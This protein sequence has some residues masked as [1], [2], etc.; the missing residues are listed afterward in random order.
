MGARRQSRSRRKSSRQATVQQGPLE[1][2]A[3]VLKGPGGSLETVERAV[4]KQQI[5][6]DA[7]GA[8]GSCSEGFE[9]ARRQSRN[10]RKSSRQATD[11]NHAAGPLEA[12]ARVLKGP[13][14][15]LETVE[16]AVGKQ[17]I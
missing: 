15:S 12:A 7:A 2:A 8:T 6:N 17:Q 1:A 4:G 11:L 9:G 3:R 13:G 5:Q 14:G 16:R 10:R